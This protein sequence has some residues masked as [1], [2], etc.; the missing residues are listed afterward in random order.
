MASIVQRN[1]RFCV[2]YLYTNEEG[3][4][5]QKWETFKTYEEAKKR[6]AEVEY[7]TQIG[8]LAVP[9]CVTLEE[10]LREFVASYGKNKWVLSVPADYESCPQVHR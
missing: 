10:L 8:K 5:K 1:G 7:H 3:K 4:R 2:V 9:K 6:Q